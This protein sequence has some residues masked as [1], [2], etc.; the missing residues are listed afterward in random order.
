M[1]SLKPLPQILLPIAT[2]A[3]LWL[4]LTAC[5]QEG[6]NTDAAY[7]QPPDEP[8]LQEE[9]FTPTKS[10]A[11]WEMYIDSNYY[12]IQYPP[13]WKITVGKG[14][15]RELLRIE[16]PNGKNA[17]TLQGLATLSGKPL[18]A[19][20]ESLATTLEV[21]VLEQRADTLGGKPACRVHYSFRTNDNRLIKETLYLTN[22]GMGMMFYYFTLSGNGPELGRIVHSIQF[23]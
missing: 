10:I 17:L 21:E 11:E 16:S 13:T 4:F 5:R 3:L 8:V 20:C 6:R 19:M 22:M 18:N 1:K 23:K 9:P 2:A 12:A 15:E 14:N 7:T